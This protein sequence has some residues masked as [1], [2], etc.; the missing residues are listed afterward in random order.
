MLPEVVVKQ[1]WKRRKD[2]LDTVDGIHGKYGDVV[3]Y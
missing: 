2:I 1:F 3:W